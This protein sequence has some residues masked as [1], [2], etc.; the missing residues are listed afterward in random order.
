MGCGPSGPVLQMGY[1][2]NDI[3]NDIELTVV[4]EGTFFITNGRHHGIDRTTIISPNELIRFKYCSTINGVGQ[5]IKITMKIPELG[6][7][8]TV[9]CNLEHMKMCAVSFCG[10]QDIGNAASEIVLYK[11]YKTVYPKFTHLMINNVVIEDIPKFHATLKQDQKNPSKKSWIDYTYYAIARKLSEPVG[12]GVP[13][14]PG[15]SDKIGKGLK[16]ASLVLDVASNFDPTGISSTAKQVSVI[17]TIFGVC[18]IF[19]LW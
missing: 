12:A 10:F 9:E 17:V 19:C 2:Y 11:D 3:G 15:T 8:S 6:Y 7:A 1:I 16:I 4:Q 5:P 14:H 18:C 13:L